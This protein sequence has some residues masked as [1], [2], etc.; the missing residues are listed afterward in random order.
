MS[1]QE[2][3]AEQLAELFHHYQEALEQ[4]SSHNKLENSESWNGLPPRERNRM[5][6]AA[7]LTLM[8]IDS[9]AKEEHDSRKYFAKPG[10]AEWGC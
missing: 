8:E 1:I 6:E 10:E 5:I 9:I 3:T 2:V 4:H 7:R